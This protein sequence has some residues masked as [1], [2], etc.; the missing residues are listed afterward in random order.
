M[1][2]AVIGIAGIVS[3]F[4]T[5]KIFSMFAVI[6]ILGFVAFQWVANFIRIRN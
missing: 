1:A 2:M 5:G 6:Y 4:S 3:A